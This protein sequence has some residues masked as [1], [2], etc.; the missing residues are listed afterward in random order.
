MVI[1]ITD[2][3]SACYTNE[4]GEKIYQQVHPQLL[5]DNDVEVSFEGI[6]EVT[7]S[8]VNVAFIEL[9]DSFDFDYIRR[10]LSFADSNRQINS[11]IKSRFDFEV[12]RR[13]PS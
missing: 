3:I 6:S 4:D 5:A 7:S 13:A 2:H 8:F 10:H 11:I 1:R 12:N 9:L